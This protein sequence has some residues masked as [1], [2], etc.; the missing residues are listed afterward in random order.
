MHFVQAKTSEATRSSES[1]SD[2]H[3]PFVREAFAERRTIYHSR[4]RST[5]MR[6]RDVHAKH[7]RWLTARVPADSQPRG[8]GLTSTVTTDNICVHTPTDDCTHVG[9]TVQL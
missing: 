5:R 4:E 8:R 6:P 9:A 7:V 2:T 1:C 3:H